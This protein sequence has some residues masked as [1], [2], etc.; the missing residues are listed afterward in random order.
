MNV[1]AVEGRRGK[2][3]K[4]GE[5]AGILTPCSRDLLG[6][7]IDFASFKDFEQQLEGRGN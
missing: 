1:E 6:V 7:G 4:G 5:G 2:E 3:G